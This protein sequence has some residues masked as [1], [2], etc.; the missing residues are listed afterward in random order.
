MQCI[1]KEKQLNKINITMVKPKCSLLVEKSHIQRKSLV[2]PRLA[3]PK[4]KT[5]TKTILIHH[6]LQKIQNKQTHKHKEN[7]IEVSKGTLIRNRYN[8][9]PHLTQ[10]TNGKVTNS[11][12]YTTNGSQEV[13]PFPAGDHKAQ[14]NKRAQRHNKHKTEKT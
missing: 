13:S 12:L 4:P 2:D 3:R 9:V 11:Q 7:T 14:I 1:I 5:S 6:I 10:D 8:Q